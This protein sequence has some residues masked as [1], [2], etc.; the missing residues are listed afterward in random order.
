MKDLKIVMM[1]VKDLIPYDN[2]PRINDNSVEYVKNSIKNFGFKVPLVIDKNNV[3]VCGH[4]RLKAS[5]ELNLKEV[6]CV[7]A[8]DLSEAQIK[9][10]RLA[11]NKVSE[12]SLWDKKK[13]DIELEDIRLE[14]ID[15]EEYGFTLA[16]DDFFVEDYKENERERTMDAYNLDDYD[17]KRTEGKYDMPKIKACNTTP[18]DLIGFNYM[19]SSKNKECGIHFYIDD[20]QFERIWNN[21]HDYLE[22]LSEYECVLTPDFSLYTE[23]PMAMKIWNTYRS[24]LIGQIMQDYGIKVIPT[25]SWCE[26]E[27]FEFCFDGLP[28]NATLSISTIGIKNSKESMKMWKKGVDEMIQ[29]L[30]PKK[31]LVYGGQVDYDFGKIKVIYYDNHVTENM[32]KEKSDEIR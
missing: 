32:K 12:M 15:M 28:K 26:E 7:V 18:S 6:P 11:D 8:D 17:H 2:N 25:I 29:R 20:Y 9:A 16:S 31:L 13:L 22:A 4:T 14:D 23:M 24:R 30:N 1:N 19:L 21:P 3:V 10:F 5:E 27:T